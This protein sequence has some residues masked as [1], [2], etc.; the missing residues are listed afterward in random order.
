MK[1]T[2]KLK[3]EIDAIS[4]MKLLAMWIFAPINDPLFEGE[5]GAYCMDRINNPEKS[6]KKGGK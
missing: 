4:R 5:S 2:S 6:Y 1:L 3:A